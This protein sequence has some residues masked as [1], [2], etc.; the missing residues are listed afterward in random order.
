MA[1]CGF[2]S[3]AGRKRQTDR[4][5]NDC[6]W[7]ASSVKQLWWQPHSTLSSATLGSGNAKPVQSMKLAC[8]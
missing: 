5:S 1:S 4:E 7:A 8:I 3:T 6:C 2:L